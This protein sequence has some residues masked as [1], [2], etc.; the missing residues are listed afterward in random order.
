MIIFN[1]EVLKD[2]EEFKSHLQ[3]KGHSKQREQGM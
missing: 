3:E 1:L 2:P